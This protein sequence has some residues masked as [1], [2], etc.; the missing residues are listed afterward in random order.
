MLRGE[1]TDGESVNKVE[2][3][4]GNFK[5]WVE[6]NE[7][8]IATAREN[9][10]LPG[11]VRENGGFYKSAFYNEMSAQYTTLVGAIELTEEEEKEI[12]Y[13]IRELSRR[14]GLF[15][16]NFKIK[17][18]VFQKDKN[19]PRALMRWDK[20]KNTLTISTTIHRL[21]DEMEYCS[22]TNLLSA[23]R[24]L[25]NKKTLSFGEEYSIESQ[26]HESVHAGK[27]KRKDK[28]K[29]K[30]KAEKKAEKKARI[31]AKKE[32]NTEV[33]IGS[34]EESIREVCTQLY[35]R[36]RYLITMKEYGVK[37]INYEKIK[38]EG[39]GYSRECDRLRGFF[40][41][42]GKIQVGELINIANK[43]I[44]SEDVLKLKMRQLG[45]KEEK[46]EE[47]LIK[48]FFKSNQTAKS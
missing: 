10:T 46:I 38:Y 41:K 31:R 26:F 19:H 43:T 34:Y 20:K 6:K 21:E 48:A 35:A 2:D 11:F 37:A 8:R 17:F 4:P 39:L 12:V 1:P 13:N 24:K 30:T 45:M 5:E 28:I 9:G 14:V 23:M 44:N 32:A 3:V 22:A 18:L 16:R 15:N 47:Y 25:Q 42:N 27:V 29:L 33:K 40:T 36:E 7:A